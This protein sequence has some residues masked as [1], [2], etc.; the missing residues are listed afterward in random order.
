MEKKLRIAIIGYG[1]MGKEIER[2][3]LERG[4][5][6]SCVIEKEEDWNVLCEKSNMAIEFTEPKAAFG[7]VLRCFDA[8]IPVVS[9][10][11]G[12][13]GKLDEAK[14]ICEQKG[15]TF[16]YSPNYSLGVNVFFEINKL[17]AKLLSPFPEYQPRISETHHTQK[18]DAPSGTAIAL[19]KGIIEKN[20]R[21]RSWHLK[22]ETTNN[23]EISVVAHRIDKVTG[24]HVVSWQGPND[25]IEIQHKAYDRS[26]FAMGAVVAAEMVLGQ[27]GFFTLKD[28][29][30]F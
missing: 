21:F 24:T 30:K 20:D 2:I 14:Q 26:I 1:K 17:L 6:I 16:V 8:K 15:Q 4:H 5:E 10:T 28:L 7:N 19:A 9:G 12:W 23:A 25:I 29:L 13:D 3:A 27:K 18:L 22:E 11:T